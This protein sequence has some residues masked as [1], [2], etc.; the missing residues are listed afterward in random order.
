[1]NPLAEGAGSEPEPMPC[2]PGSLPCMNSCSMR[3]ICLNP[4]SINKLT[5][6]PSRSTDSSGWYLL[7]EAFSHRRP[8]A[9]P[10]P[11]ALHR[12]LTQLRTSMRFQDCLVTTHQLPFPRPPLPTLKRHSTSSESMIPGSKISPAAKTARPPM[13]SPQHKPRQDTLQ[14]GRGRGFCDCPHALGQQQTHIHSA[15]FQNLPTIRVLG[16]AQRLHTPDGTKVQEQAPPGD[17]SGS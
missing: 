7:S 11:R 17:C 13:D 10:E 6:T 12:G 9:G 4:S 2:A 8:D 15:V 5:L 16:P 1:M 14:R 3:N